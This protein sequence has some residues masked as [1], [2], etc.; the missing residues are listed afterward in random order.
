[1]RKMIE[2]IAK[3]VLENFDNILYKS[4]YDKETIKLLKQFYCTKSKFDENKTLIME[5]S[6]KL[7]HMTKIY[8]LTYGKDN[9]ESTENEQQIEELPEEKVEE[10]VVNDICI[11]E[12][13]DEQNII[14]NIENDEK[15]DK[16]DA[17]TNV[18]Q[19]TENNVE[20]Q[21][22]I[23]EIL[24]DDNIIEENI[25]G[26][27]EEPEL[28]ADQIVNALI[29]TNLLEADKVIKRILKK[30]QNTDNENSGNDVS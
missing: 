9:V 23:F 21:E 3:A 10:V 13:S 20:Q 7:I 14:E 18:E 29:N 15:N 6:K 16:V 5:E 17:E 4:N 27:K 12:E 28:Q 25:E 2:K 22:E 11:A 30:D 24:E 19:S 1:M 8:D 26:K